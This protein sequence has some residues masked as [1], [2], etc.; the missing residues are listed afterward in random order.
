MAVTNHNAC[1]RYLL[2][3]DSLHS[4]YSPSTCEWRR[5]PSAAGWGRSGGS[6]GPCSSI[7]NWNWQ[8]ER[9]NFYPAVISHCRGQLTRSSSMPRSGWALLGRPCKKWSFL[10]ISDVW[11]LSKFK[12]CAKNLTIFANFETKQKKPWKKPFWAAPLQVD[13]R[14]LSSLKLWI[15]QMKVVVQNYII[16]V[17]GRNWETK[18]SMSS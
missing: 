1:N 9:S 11:Y 5:V 18:L 8:R 13:L 15:K 16:K 2:H 7:T 6:S 17:F 4:L 14:E 3:K 12:V 10:V